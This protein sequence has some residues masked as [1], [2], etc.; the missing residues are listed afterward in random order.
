M[1]EGAEMSGPPSKGE[2]HVVHLYPREMSIYGD[3]GNTRARW[4]RGCVGTVI[5]R[6]CT[7]T[8]PARSSPSTRTSCSAAAARTPGRRG[9]RRI[10]RRSGHAWWSWQPPGRRC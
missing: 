3:L 10:W 8:T 1:S 9:S 6:W 2:V 7:T 4:S 5:R